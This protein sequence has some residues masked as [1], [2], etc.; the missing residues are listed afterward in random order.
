M[1]KNIKV[2]FDKESDFLEVMFDVKAGYFKETENEDVMEKVD[3]DGNVIGFSI[4]HVSSDSA[5][6]CQQRGANSSRTWLMHRGP[7]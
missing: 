1:E 5:Q 6:C 3:A 2:W 4:L 7:V